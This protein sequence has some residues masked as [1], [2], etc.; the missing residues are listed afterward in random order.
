VG[1]RRLLRPLCRLSY[2]HAVTSTQTAPISA[3]IVDDEKPARD[4]LAYLL[5][6]FPE[7]RVV[8][9]GKNGLEAVALI[10]EHAPDLVFLDV[11]M[12][13]LDGFGVLRKLVERKLSVPHIVF[14]TAFDNYAVHA[15]EVNAVDYVLKPFDRERIAV[16]V[17]RAKRMIEGRSATSERLE[18]LLEQLSAP[19]P[20]TGAPVK[21]L[22]KVAGRLLL[23]SADEIV[24]GTIDEGV[25]TVH[26]REIEGV[27]N[28]RTIDEL[29]SA[30]D[31]DAFWRPH[32]SHIVNINHIK[33]VVPWFKSSYMLRMADRRQS[34]IPVSRTQTR[35]LREL[36]K[37]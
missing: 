18:T 12:P 27:S 36:F 31:S 30:L 20:K 7:V 6:S 26:T 2:T 4:E 21:L 25:I 34:E 16:A 3:L 33:E 19:K 5:K 15:F 11:Q 9:Q 35:R 28:F 22:L 23:V 24:C 29:Q 13:G 14:A 8:G 37:L 32:R 1:I 10:K 17:E